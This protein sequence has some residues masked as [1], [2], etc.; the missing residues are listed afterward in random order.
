MTII[1][2]HDAFGSLVS[3]SREGYEI[4][5]KKEAGGHLLGHYKN[6]KFT[7][8]EAVPYNTPKA[9]RSSWDPNWT[10]FER[11]GSRLERETRLSWLG[12]YH[13]HPETG[14]YASARPSSEDIESFMDST[15]TI[16]LIVRISANIKKVPDGCCEA[17]G[18]ETKYQYVICGYCKM[19]GKIEG[20]LVEC[21]KDS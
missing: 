15:H 20:V 5:G 7:V 10:N 2:N 1:I 9:T 12:V 14:G 11:E 3:H 4:K 16:E 13:S 19:N 6:G 18:L 21:A 17:I 8:I